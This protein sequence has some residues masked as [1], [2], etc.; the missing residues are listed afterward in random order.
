M[1]ATLFND[2]IY[3]SEIETEERKQERINCSVKEKLM[4]YWGYK[5]EDYVTQ[6]IHGKKIFISLVPRVFSFFDM[7]EDVE[8]D[9]LF[10]SLKALK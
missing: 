10:N 7:K 1:A 9:F 2:T 6:S 8:K 5:F 3:I 4:T